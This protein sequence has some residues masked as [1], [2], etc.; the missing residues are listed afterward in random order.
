MA[1]AAAGLEL[2][3]RRRVRRKAAGVRVEQE[4]EYLVGAEVRHEDE[5]VRAV[6]ADRVR[7]AGGRNDLQRGAHAAVGRDR[8]DTHQVAA[9]RRP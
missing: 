1:R 5:A 3:E 4:L 7:V 6:G 8:I 9:V 2:Y